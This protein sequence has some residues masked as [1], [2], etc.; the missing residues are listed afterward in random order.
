MLNMDFTVD[1]SVWQDG[2][3]ARSVS[4]PVAAARPETDMPKAMNT[5]SFARQLISLSTSGAQEEE[6]KPRAVPAPTV[7]VK[8]EKGIPQIPAALADETDLTPFIVS[9]SSAAKPGERLNS[10]LERTVFSNKTSSLRTKDSP[11]NMSEEKAKA[12][13]ARQNS[14]KTMTPPDKAKLFSMDNV[15]RFRNNETKFGVAQPLTAN[16]SDQTK[17]LRIDEMRQQAK[18]KAI[19]ETNTSLTQKPASAMIDPESIRAQ[20]SSEGFGYKRPNL[21][22]ASSEKVSPA[23]SWFPEA[24]TR[25][26]DAYEAANKVAAQYGASAAGYKN[27]TELNI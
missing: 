3:T 4:I 25:Q 1:L 12:R 13:E 5:P 14:A 16:V 26:L 9:A 20:V 19:N 15:A 8:Q 24:M 18:A 23:A 10:E 11:Y 21:P 17:Q 27:Q 7:L 2:F 22:S 6:I